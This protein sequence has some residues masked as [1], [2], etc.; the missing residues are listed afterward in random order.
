MNNHSYVYIPVDKLVEIMQESCPP[1]MY[2]GHNK[3]LIGEV[4][5]CRKCWLSWLKDGD[6]NG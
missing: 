3:C 6:S 1:G 5:G 2:S 4:K